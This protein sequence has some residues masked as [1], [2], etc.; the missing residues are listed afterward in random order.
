MHFDL[1][2]SR[3]GS[4]RPD[5]GGS[6]FNMKVKIDNYDNDGGDNFV[7]R[8][9]DSDLDGFEFEVIEETAERWEKIQTDYVNLQEE[10]RELWTKARNAQ[11]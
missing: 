7:V 8:Q 6:T 4:H 3:G 11:F 5:S 2:C 9:A 10:L 1:K